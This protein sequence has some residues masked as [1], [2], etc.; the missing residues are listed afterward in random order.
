MKKISRKR[1]IQFWKKSTTFAVLGF[2]L[3]VV[4]SLTYKVVPLAIFLAVIETAIVVFMAIKGNVRSFICF[5]L[6]FASVTIENTLFTEGKHIDEVY[7][8]LNLPG[9]AYYHLFFMLFFFYFSLLLSRKKKYV[10]NVR[11]DVCLISIFLLGFIMLVYSISINDNGLTSIEGMV[12]F[13]IIDAYE[14]LWILFLALIILFSFDNY[15]EF[16]NELKEISI[17]TLVGVSLAGI[18]LF[19][20]GNFSTWSNTKNLICPLMFFFSPALILIA[21]ERKNW[22]PYFLLGAI[23]TLVQIKNT[24]G[25]PGAF[26]LYL[27]LVVL[28]FYIKFFRNLR[29]CAK[30]PLLF[31][32][33]IATL[34]AIPLVITYLLSLDPDS[35]YVSFKLRKMVDMLS[36]EGGF[37]TWYKSVGNSIGIR[38]EQFINAFIELVNKPWAFI[39][40]KGY[41]GTIT[42]YWGSYNWDVYGNIY[43]DLQVDNKVYSSFL[44]G[45]V[46]LIINF[47]LPGILFVLLL[48]KNFVVEVF[49][50]KGSWM[51]VMGVFWLFVFFYFYNSM[52]IGLVWFCIGCYERKTKAREVRAV[53]PVK[54][55]NTLISNGPRIVKN[56]Y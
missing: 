36:F 10:F 19:L 52:A 41:G 33:S 5:Y 8:F 46:E 21:L 53:S 6:L 55:R 49:R 15:P 25:I 31:V 3:A 37:E 20:I 28:V 35:N 54:K 7:S 32:A 1:T 24:L 2:A 11:R 17:K 22:L 12:R 40:G 14:T 51:Y 13:S 38:V 39:L 47:G 56:N 27:F 34:I 50:K 4:N 30:K 18:F 43:P 29:R 48:T 9:I 16:K 23:S 44:T 45:I 42:R 26:W